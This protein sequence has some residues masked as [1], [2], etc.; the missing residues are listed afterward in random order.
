MIKKKSYEGYINLLV[1]F[2]SMICGFFVVKEM[3]SILGSTIYGA[4][5][6]INSVVG[7]ISTADLGV[8]NGMRNEI[9][10]AYAL[11]ETKKLQHI[12]REFL[13]SLLCISMIVLL[14]FILVTEVF[15]RTSVFE[16]T[17]RLPS[18]VAVLFGCFNLFLG[19]SHSISL[20]LQR[21]TWSSFSKCAA[22]L[23]V[24]VT[25]LALSKSS[26]VPSLLGVSILNSLPFLVSNIV[27]L[28]ALDRDYNLHIFNHKENALG[29]KCRFIPSSFSFCISFFLLQIF[30][31]LINSTDLVIIKYLYS[32]E[33]V[34][35]YS[36][37]LK[38]YNS[39]SVLFTA[40]IYSLWSNV[41]YH[42]SMKDFGWIRNTINKNLLVCSL[43]SIGV[44]VVS[45]YL[46]SIM[47]IWL[48]D[49]CVI[50]NTFCI[51]VFAL[52]C[53]S[54]AFNSIYTNCLNGMGL[55]KIELLLGAI[56]AVGNIPLSI[57]LA[58]NLN[59]GMAGVKLATTIWTILAMVVFM[60]LVR[61]TISKKEV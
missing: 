25:Y 48:K 51:V 58:R 55:I 44:I 22:N 13:N 24:L 18:Y 23:F 2:V 50:Y 19:S 47:K 5:I 3:L 26:Y 36:N 46:N 14:V 31:I 15:I 16:E 61:R 38:I 37:I 59:M 17:Y 42:Y 4:W 40:F 35:S 43:F 32:E 52:C 34:T 11:Q 53:I 33:I 54:Q 56:E 9:A 6:V 41:T 27:L 45:L 10:K 20:A 8:G 1:Q 57:F 21:S 30:A 39:G 12:V 29:F 28:W 60:M 7:W 49:N